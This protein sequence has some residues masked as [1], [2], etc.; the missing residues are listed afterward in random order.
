[1]KKL[2]AVAIASAFV[3]PAAF[4]EVTIYGSIRAGLGYIDQ[5]NGYTTNTYDANFNPVAGVKSQ[6]RAQ[7]RVTDE[8]SRI[9]FE[10]SDKLSSDLSVVWRVESAVRVGFNKDNTINNGVDFAGRETWIGLRSKSWGDVKLARRMDDEYQM[11]AHSP[12][13][14][15]SESIKMF[16]SSGPIGRMSGDKVNNGID[17][18]SPSWG[19]FQ[20]AV[21]WGTYKLD[22]S[23]AQEFN[24]GVHADQWTANAQYVHKYFETGVAFRQ[25]N[26]VYTDLQHS[27]ATSTKT[28]T[29]TELANLYSKGASGTGA[30]IGNAGGY[31]RGLEVALAV[32]PLNGLKIAAVWERVSS[33]Y[34]QT[35]AGG[36]N[37]VVYSLAR[38]GN[39]Y[40][41]INSSKKLH[42]DNWGLGVEYKTGNWAL[43][44]SYAHQSSTKGDLL[45]GL[46]DGAWAAKVEATYSLTKQTKILSGIQY[47]SSDEGRTQTSSAI[48]STYSGAQTPTVD[49]SLG[50]KRWTALVGLRTDF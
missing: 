8:G 39:T 33:K 13:K 49:G 16:T 29:V 26:D 25:I 5:G 44:T 27:S 4:A 21:G 35:A 20:F 37:T 2:I 11:S 43:R 1:M 17:Y 24:Q 46:D 7:F 31:T 42:E 9:G 3:A 45:W 22:G 15:D 30:A 18:K 41:V 14:S 48:G 19:G 50:S 6:T 12:L 40:S 28:A 36:V 10:G 34:N 32:K 38:T 47:A 23:L